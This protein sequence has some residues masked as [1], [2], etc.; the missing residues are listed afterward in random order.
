MK[1]VIFVSRFCFQ[2][3]SIQVLLAQYSISG[4]TWIQCDKAVDKGRPIYETNIGQTKTEARGWII[5]E[6]PQ[7]SRISIVVDACPAGLMI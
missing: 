7:C 5:A 1:G 3:T 4:Q 6:P 2:I